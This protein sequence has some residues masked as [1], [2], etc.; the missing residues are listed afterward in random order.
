MAK[1]ESRKSIL[2]NQAVR[3]SKE[4]RTSQS[5]KFGGVRF[6]HNFGDAI[7]SRESIDSQLDDLAQESRNTSKIQFMT[8]E[9][10]TSIQKMYPFYPTNSNLAERSKQGAEKNKVISEDTRNKY[11]NRSNAKITKSR[12]EK[13][14][15]QSDI[16]SQ[17]QHVYD[18]IKFY[19]KTNSE[20]IMGNFNK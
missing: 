17:I 9:P 1:I 11:F 13:Y 8:D 4:L 14:E 2:K 16:D 20:N 15:Q 18:N 3:S 10:K 7:L 12:I 19:P 5:P 6:S